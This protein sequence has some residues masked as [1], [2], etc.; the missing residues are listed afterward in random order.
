MAVGK[1]LLGWPRVGVTAR[2]GRG[3][4]VRGADGDEVAL[5]VEDVLILGDDGLAKI[6]GK[7]G[8]VIGG[9]TIRYASLRNSSRVS[10]RVRGECLRRTLCFLRS[11]LRRDVRSDI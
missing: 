5:E 2:W 4:E 1:T 8:S 6:R 9:F 11:S 10:E 3:G 7:G